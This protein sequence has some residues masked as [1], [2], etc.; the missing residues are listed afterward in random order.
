MYQSQLDVAKT[1][2]TAAP[3]L[4]VDASEGRFDLAS[5]EKVLVVL[6]ANGEAC[7]HCSSGRRR[8]CAFVVFRRPSRSEPGM[9]M[10]AQQKWVSFEGVVQ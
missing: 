5:S 4:L 9:A 7:V 8:R 6:V 10:P 2:G 1:R 3:M